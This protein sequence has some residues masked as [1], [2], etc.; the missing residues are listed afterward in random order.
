MMLLMWFSLICFCQIMMLC[1]ENMTA[2][3]TSIKREI[4]FSLIALALIFV[5][6]F[7]V[8]F[9][10][11]LTGIEIEIG[12]E[13]AYC[14]IG[15]V[16]A[17][18]L[19][20]HHKNILKGL[21]SGVLCTLY[22][23]GMDG[24][25]IIFCRLIGY[26]EIPDNLRFTYYIFASLSLAS[27]LIA[28][29]ILKKRI[30]MNIFNNK[31]MYLVAAISAVMIIITYVN[32]IGVF[33]DASGNIMYA[34]FFVSVIAMFVIIVRYAFKENTMR[35]QALIADASK[36]YIN[37]LERSYSSMRTIK[38][39]YVNIMTSFKLYIENGDMEGLAKYYNDE[40]SEMNKDLLLQ[41]QMLGNLQN[42]QISEVKSVLIYK[43]SMAT[44][45]QI[46]TSIEVR[47][48]VEEL[49]VSTAIVCQ[50]IG[51]LL[52]NAIEAVEETDRKK[53]SIAIIK[54]TGSKTII[55][56]NTWK[57]KEIEI[58]KLFELGFSTKE[59]GGGVG[60]YTVRN[61][62]NKIDRL[63]LETELGTEYFTQTLTVKDG[64]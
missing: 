57:H 64:R 26:D 2:L 14:I 28:K 25:T 53:L 51:I 50:I 41:D 20:F 11:G 15:L 40:L 33:T 1:F 16:F 60:L 32:Y 10:A 9:I 36:K 63:Y 44:Q 29:R 6:G 38:H 19:G 47:E 22:A 45:H 54:N 58:N 61:Y 4:V 18:V 43:C 35:T 34:L 37:D 27:V 46:D 59:K 62:T 12:Y 3:K 49:G 56:K 8:G 31:S 7:I 24:V 5:V 17:V 42:V 23:F 55:I 13:L 52:D 48:P 30:D 21:A 39:D